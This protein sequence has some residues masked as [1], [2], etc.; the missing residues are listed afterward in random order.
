MIVSTYALTASLAS[1]AHRRPRRAQRIVVVGAGH[2]GLVAANYLADSGHN[3]T[4]LEASE[5]IG[6]MA[7]SAPFAAAAPHH[8]LSPC[9]IDAVYWNAST[10]ASDL[11]LS[12]YGL[13]VVSHDPA[14]AWVGSEGE[15]LV[16][17]RDLPRTIE[18]IRRFSA[19]DA[20]TYER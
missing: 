3:V 2:N 18:E 13:R 4:V 17:Q 10:V 12:R 20:R 9:A 19:A 6:G 14:W 8:L 11:Q 7:A 15:S 16:L 1:S 5:R